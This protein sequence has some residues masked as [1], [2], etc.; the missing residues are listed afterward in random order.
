MTKTLKEHIF[1]IG[2]M[3]VGKTTTSHKLSEKLGAKEVDTDAMI[4]E[5]EGKAISHIFEDEGEEYFR[6]VETETIEQLKQLD[7]AI[8]SCGGG[9]V[10]REENV[11]KMKAQGKIVLLTATPETIY[12]HVKDST[13]RPLL[14]GNMNIP[15]ITKLMDA[16]APKYQAAADAV[17][18]TDGCTPEQVADKIIKEL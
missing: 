12:E 11:E 17:I 4:V 6:K 7:P 16:R 2:F 10:M 18:P 1:L 13:N 15:Y 9:M 5:K 3:G 8:V 14:N